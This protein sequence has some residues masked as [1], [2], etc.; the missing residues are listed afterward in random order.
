MIYFYFSYN[1]LGGVPVLFKN[2]ARGLHARQVEFGLIA[3]ET[4]AISQLFQREFP[5]IRKFF[6]D[7]DSESES[8]LAFFC[9]NDLFVV[10]FWEPDLISFRMCNPKIFFWNVF[11]NTLLNSNL[12]HGRWVCHKSNILLIN[13]LLNSNSLILMDDSPLVKLTSYR[14]KLTKEFV[15]LPIPVTVNINTF[16]PKAVGITHTNRIVNISYITRFETWKLFPLVRIICDLVN[17]QL[18]F[19][20]A[21]K[22]ITN[23]IIETESFLNQ[24]INFDFRSALS[25]DFLDGME[26]EKLDNFLKQEIHLNI[27]MGT[28]CLESAKFGIPTLL[29]N[30]SYSLI[31][32][33]K[34]YIELHKTKNYNLGT[35]EYLNHNTYIS[36]VQFFEAYY[37]SAEKLTLLSRNTFDYVSYHHNLNI[38]VEKFEYL[39]KIA[40]IHISEIE[41]H[42]YE[43]SG[44]YRFYKILKSSLLNLISKS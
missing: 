42:I 28:S 18:N 11:P 9:K 5:S 41:H 36:L 43:Y 21:L 1:S 20:V 27:G 3:N 33:D 17:I 7:R 24:N 25:I 19:K 8:I 23:D 14:K 35:F 16:L 6:L 4:S 37:P 40:E 22:I 30:P 26:G 34:V 15:Y 10:S 38:I 32:Q 12:R 44:Y 31:H 29:I 39:A 13:K 2:I